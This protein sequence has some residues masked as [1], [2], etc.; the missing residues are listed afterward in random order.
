MDT[1]LTRSLLMFTFGLG[2]IMLGLI[3]D[4][5][6]RLYIAINPEAMD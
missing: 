4:P 2:L 5:P 1:Y 6:I 3:L